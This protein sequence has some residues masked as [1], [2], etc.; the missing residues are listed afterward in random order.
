[1]SLGY[2]NGNVLLSEVATSREPPA[3]WLKFS[4]PSCDDAKTSGEVSPRNSTYSWLIVACNTLPHY[5][6]WWWR[7]SAWE[8]VVVAG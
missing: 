7:G 2:S 5:L 6:R 3:C 1:M 4:E 8:R